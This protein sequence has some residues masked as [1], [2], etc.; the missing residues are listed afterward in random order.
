MAVR[1]IRRLRDYND[2]ALVRLNGVC[3]P[4]HVVISGVEGELPWLDGVTYLGRD[5]LAPHLLLPTLLQPHVP[6]DLF[7]RA[8][9]RAHPSAGTPLAVLAGQQLISTRLALPLSRSALDAWLAH[10]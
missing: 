5:P 4:G 10:H 1:L 9:L 3:A 7:E 8:L 2:D 6:I